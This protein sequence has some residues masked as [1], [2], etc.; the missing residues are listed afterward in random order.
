MEPTLQELGIDRM[1]QEVR[2]KLIAEIWE[3]LS[4]SNTPI[5]DSHRAELDRRL[6]DADLNPAASRPWE[7]VRARLRGE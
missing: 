1:S 6:I 7:E 3:S 2:L 4:L 5:P